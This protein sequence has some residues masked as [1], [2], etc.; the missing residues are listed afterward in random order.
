MSPRVVVSLTTSP[1]RISQI[2]DVIHCIKNQTYQVSRIY[3]NLPH[4]FK[5]TGEGYTIPNFLRND[6]LIYI[7]RCED[8]GPATKIVPTVTHEHDDD[9][10][11]IIISIDD[12]ILYYNTFVKLYIDYA[13][14]FKDSVITG[15]SYMYLSP[16]FR[17]GHLD[18]RSVELLEGFSGVA[19]RVKFLKGIE[20]E[21]DFSKLPKS[22]YAS[23]DFVLSNYIL[24]KG[25][26]IKVINE[27]L[28]YKKLK[29]L[30]YGFGEDALHKGAGTD[31]S[32]STVNETKYK[33]CSNYLQSQNDL[34]ISY[35]R[36]KGI[37]AYI[38]NMLFKF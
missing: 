24:K 16:S 11:T 37:F 10:N 5:R 19:Y 36:N 35:Y 9:D 29:E 28:H 32:G 17:Q 33:Q 1:Q 6:P 2:G 30:S 13:E 38:K 4:V 26:K 31:L 27:S 23:D 20:N 3:I 25:Y 15:K 21:I 12:D 22:C 14:T 7:N 8:I 34:Y 18:A